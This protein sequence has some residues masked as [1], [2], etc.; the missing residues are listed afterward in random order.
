M[1]V[2]VGAAIIRDARVLAAR[3]TRPAELAGQ[4][5]FRGGKSEPGGSGPAALAR[6]CRE[7]LGSAVVA[8]P[9]IGAAT[10]R[11]GLVLRVYRATLADGSAEPAIGEDHDELRW[12]AAD[13][14]DSVPWLAPDRPIVAALRDELRRSG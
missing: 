1:R 14:L 11:A 6:E 8:G 10:V 2:V 3:R 7:E 12:L 5:E 9:L 4:W 13:D